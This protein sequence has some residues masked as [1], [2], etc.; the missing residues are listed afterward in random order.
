MRNL[1]LALIMVFLSFLGACNKELIAV[2]DG[3]EGVERV[4]VLR[5]MMRYM[6]DHYSRIYSVDRHGVYDILAENDVR[7]YI[8]LD[9]S[10]IASV[11]FHKLYGNTAFKID[12]E[13]NIEVSKGDA[14]SFRVTLYRE[15][16]DNNHPPYIWT[17]CQIVS[18]GLPYCAYAV[19]CFLTGCT[20]GA[21]YYECT[22]SP[23]EDPEPVEPNKN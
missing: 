3:A 15:G 7:E 19:K 13:R 16:D 6:E 22:C 9:D 17:C 2:R 21:C 11:H 1:L 8:L 5:A 20:S 14:G 4:Y 10:C 18:D 23:I 12:L